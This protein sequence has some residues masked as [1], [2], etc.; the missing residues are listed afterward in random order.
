VL[1][2]NVPCQAEADLLLYR[3]LV[4]GKTPVENI[5]RAAKQGEATLLTY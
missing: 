5:L 4:G 1:D 2:D 3:V